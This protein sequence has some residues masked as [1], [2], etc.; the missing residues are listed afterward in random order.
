MPPLVARQDIIA[1][2]DQSELDRLAVAYTLQLGRLFCAIGGLEQGT[3]G[4]LHMHISIDNGDWVSQH[5]G[6][7]ESTFGALVSKLEVRGVGGR[8]L[9]YLR[10]INSLRNFVVHR[11]FWHFPFPGDEQISEDWLSDVTIQLEKWHKHFQTAAQ[12]LTHI[13]LQAEMLEIAVDFGTEGR[14]YS[15]KKKARP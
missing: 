14:L 13:F 7:R 11:F 10:K 12:R 2:I 3:V 5:K 15:P 8:N 6:L 4:L 9:A 1:L